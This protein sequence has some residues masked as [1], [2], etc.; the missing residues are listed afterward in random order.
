MDQ[1]C[2]YIRLDCSVI[3]GTNG[4]VVTYHVVTLISR[5]A[6]L[7]IYAENSRPAQK[8][9]L[10]FLHSSLKESQSKL[11]KKQKRIYFSFL[12]IPFF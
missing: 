6:R 11:T 4:H 3:Y 12:Q 2:M 10:F 1:V 7:V 9:F 8:I 5:L